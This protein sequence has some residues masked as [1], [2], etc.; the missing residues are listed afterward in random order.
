MDHSQMGEHKL[1]HGKLFV[2]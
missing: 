1:Q 2:R